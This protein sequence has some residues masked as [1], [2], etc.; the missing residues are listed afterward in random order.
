MWTDVLGQILSPVLQVFGHSGHPLLCAQ[1]R[2]LDSPDGAPVLTFSGATWRSPFRLSPQE[3]AKDVLP[4]I[5]ESGYNC[6]SL[7]LVATLKLKGKSNFCPP[8]KKMEQFSFGRRI[9]LDVT[10]DRRSWLCCFGVRVCVGI[11]H[12]QPLCARIPCQL[13]LMCFPKRSQALIKS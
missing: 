3:F 11:L 4:R 9:R 7:Q 12:Q 6:I 2:S 1:V 10:A 13:G 5:K 8:K